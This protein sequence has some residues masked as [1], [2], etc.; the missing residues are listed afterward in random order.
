MLIWEI[1]V[2]RVWKEK[3]MYSYLEKCMIDI[4]KA[5]SYVLCEKKF[6]RKWRSIHTCKHIFQLWKMFIMIEDIAMI[7]EDA[8]LWY[9]LK[10]IMCP[11]I[12]T[13]VK[14]MRGI[15]WIKWNGVTHLSWKEWSCPGSSLFN[16]L[17]SV[18]KNGSKLKLNQMAQGQV[19]TQKQKK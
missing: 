10:V 16:S 14:P 19:F 18:T 9:Q 8:L 5:L 2:T 6:H 11:T 17:V 15:K 12:Y 3:F 7:R 4:S 13:N 1:C